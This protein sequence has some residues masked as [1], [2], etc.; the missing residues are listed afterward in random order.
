MVVKIGGHCLVAFGG[1]IGGGASLDTWQCGIRVTSGVGS[2]DS[3]DPSHGYV[4][5]PDVYLSRLYGGLASWFT[6]ALSV[7]AGSEFMALRSDATL[8]WVKAN[9]ITGG[10]KPPDVNTGKYLDRTKTNI[11]TYGTV[12]G[13]SSGTVPGFVTASV[14]LLTDKQRG[15][16]H[17][18]RIYL[19]FALISVASGRLTTQ[20]QTGCIKTVK[21]LL[22]VLTA[23]KD[24]IPTGGADTPVTPVISSRVDGSLNVIRSITCG[25]VYDVQRRRK[26]Q[27]VE[28]YS[29]PVAFP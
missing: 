1:H 5:Q 25:D 20:N 10:T 9:N 29:T 19:P 26:E 13:A 3:D 4:L 23:A 22:N 7:T 18:G 14:S 6:T 8:E 24:Q 2:T 28:S 17:R 16:G 11:H 15:P 12:V 21:A 27:L